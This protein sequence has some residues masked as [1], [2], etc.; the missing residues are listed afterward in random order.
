MSAPATSVTDDQEPLNVP[1]VPLDSVAESRSTTCAE[2]SRPEPASLPQA[3]L[4]V[5]DAVVYQGPPES[6]A[7]WPVGAVESGVTVN[8]PALVEPVPFVIVTVLA[9]LALALFVQEYEVENGLVESV[10]ESEPNTVGNATLVIPLPPSLAFEV[11]VKLPEF[12]PAG[13]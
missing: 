5:T 10:V 3:R 1:H 7:D 12:E 6:A 4:R 11:A 2:L 9:P 13:A 8:V